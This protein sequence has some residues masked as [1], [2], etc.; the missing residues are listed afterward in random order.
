[1]VCYCKNA[2]KFYRIDVLFNDYQPRD[3]LRMSFPLDHA[4]IGLSI[5]LFKFAFSD[6]IY[7]L[8]VRMVDSKPKTKVSVY[9]SSFKSCFSQISRI[10]RIVGL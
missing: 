5:E 9:I 2:G 1:M 4:T 8:D 6:Q 10:V 3:Y 7:K